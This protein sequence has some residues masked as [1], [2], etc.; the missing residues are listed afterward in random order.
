M[1]PWVWIASIGTIGILSGILWKDNDLF[2]GAENVFVGASSGYYFYMAFKNLRDLAWNPITQKGQLMLLIPIALGLM[3]YSRY[4]KK[5]AWMSR[6]GA[7]FLIAVGSGLALFATVTSQLIAQIRANFLPLTS[8]NNLVMVVATLSVVMYF[9]FSFER[10]GAAEGVARL[11]RWV[12]MITF[13]VSFGNVVMG[14]ISLLLGVLDR[15]LGTWL[16]ML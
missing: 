5:Y 2:R 11:G 1:D 14:R 8:L 15:L 16:G 10:K 4:F 6:W 13:G 7:A 3:L 9:F 12:M